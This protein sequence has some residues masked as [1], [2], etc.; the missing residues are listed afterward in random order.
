MVTYNDFSEYLTAFSK[1]DNNPLPPLL[2]IL[3]ISQELKPQI[4]TISLSDIL[5]IPP[6]ERNHFP[7][8][9]THFGSRAAI[10]H[11][12]LLETSF[13]SF[14]PDLLFPAS[15]VVFYPGLLLLFQ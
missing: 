1:T 8:L 6:W 14:M 5:L 12:Q 3:Y 7:S 2:S 13:A 15:L 4:L 9:L 11:R 10:S